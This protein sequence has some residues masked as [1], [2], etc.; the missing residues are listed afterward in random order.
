MDWSGRIIREDKRSAIS[1]QRPQLLSILGLDNETWL[2][3]ASSFGKDYHG[4]VGS[5]EALATYASN[6]GKRWIASKNELRLH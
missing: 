6:T 1:N 3:L 2:S 5:L 4:A